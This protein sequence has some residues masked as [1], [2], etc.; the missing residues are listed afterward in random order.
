MDRAPACRLGWL[1]FQPSG[2]GEPIKQ[3]LGLLGVERLSQ[4]VTA[5]VLNAD[6]PN[7]G[8]CL[9]PPQ[10]AAGVGVALGE[11]DLPQAG[12]SVRPEIIPDQLDGRCHAVVGDLF[13]L[14]G[15]DVYGP[16]EVR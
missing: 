2:P 15:V 6:F 1:S 4:R 5:N 3:F 13:R 14:G 7:A 8:V 16:F 10:H 12:P 9:E 11:A